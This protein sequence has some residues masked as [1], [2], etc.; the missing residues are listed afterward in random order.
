MG[1]EKWQQIP[2][3][4]EISA[5]KQGLLL[6]WGKL[7]IAVFLGAVQG[8]RSWEEGTECH[9]GGVTERHRKRK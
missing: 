8:D 5:E 6:R 4:R 9:P 7:G 1:T 3:R 2:G